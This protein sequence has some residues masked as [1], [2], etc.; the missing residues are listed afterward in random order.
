[1]TDGGRADGGILGMTAGGI[2]G[3]ADGGRA[4]GGMTAGGMAG[5]LGMGG[6][7][8]WSWAEVRFV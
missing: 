1:M 7:G 8:E 3:M 6:R 4:D 2:L 5:A